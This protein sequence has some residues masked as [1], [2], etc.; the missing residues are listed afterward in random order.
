MRGTAAASPAV[1]IREAMGHLGP[2]LRRRP[3]RAWRGW[4][5]VAGVAASLVANLLLL[6]LVHT[7][8][9]G[10]RGAASAPRSVALSPLSSRSWE[11]NRRVT[12]GSRPA[13]PS[14][15]PRA[16]APPRTRAESP[17]V[18]PPAPPEP[19]A[20]ALARQQVVDVAPGNEKVPDQSR[21][22]AETNNSVEK[23][24]VSRFARPGAERTTPRPT[25]STT[26][27]PVPKEPAPE[28]ARAPAAAGT[29]RGDTRRVGA[30]GAAEPSPATR[31]AD[32][33]AL[34]LDPA[35]LRP[36]RPPEAPPKG[37]A[38]APGEGGEGGEGSPDGRP[39]API[40]KPSAAFYDQMAGNAFPDHVEGKDVGDAT[41]LN[42]REWKYAG[43]FNRIKQTVAEN[44]DPGS[45]IRARDPRGERF[46][47]KDRDTVLTIT[48]ARDGTLKD[49]K[50]SK[51]SG[52]D[53]L[54]QTAVDAF[55]RSQPF[56]NPPPGLLDPQG[57]VRFSFG[58]HIETGGGGLF[59][60]FG[61][62]GR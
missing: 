27:V 57:E 16:P 55:S 22:L 42:T 50:V 25:Q 23:E 60:F 12:D 43:F 56:S 6:G 4:R 35:G 38:Q 7:D 47:Y 46:M 62:P 32:R 37:A 21:L 20:E 31:P 48:L 52:I 9:I 45:A 18:A 59:R 14:T 17:R 26:P 1:N 49:V 28:V 40:L 2:S 54:D 11:A 13:P 30:P 39:G 8:W 41:F 36:A 5:L 10:I 29:R 24:S 58:F 19:A 33:L 15:P 3:R 61:P 51:S 34:N 44:W 53:F